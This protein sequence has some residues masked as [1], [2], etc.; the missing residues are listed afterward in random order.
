MGVTN[1]YMESKIIDTEP[2]YYPEPTCMYCG[3]VCDIY[4]IHPRDEQLWCWCKDCKED[5][6]HKP[7]NSTDE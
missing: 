1:E 2:D 7:I 3:K 5:T 6:F 4:E